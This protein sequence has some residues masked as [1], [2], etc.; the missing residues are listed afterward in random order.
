MIEIRRANQADVER[1]YEGRPVFSMKG[2]VAE[3]DGELLGIGGVFRNGGH[4]Y[5]FA[6]MLPESH[7]WAKSIL[8]MAKKV[9]EDVGDDTVYAVRQED[10]PTAD[11]LLKHL[12]FVEV[13]PGN[14]LYRRN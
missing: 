8:R 10:E 2:Y 12:G 11:R 4:R 3:K 6:E 14:N 7:R 5:A 13:A 1:W 9:M